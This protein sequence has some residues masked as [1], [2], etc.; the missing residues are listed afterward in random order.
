MIA[1]PNSGIIPVAARKRPTADDLAAILAGDDKPKTLY[2]NRPL[3]NASDVIEWARAAGFEKTLRPDD[4][5][6]TIAFSKTPVDWSEVGDSFDGVVVPRASKQKNGARSVEKLGD[7]GAVVLRFES[8]DLTQRWQAIRNVGG[9]WDYPSYKPHITFTM[10]DGDID[11]SAIE[12]YQGALEF[13]PEVFQEIGS[14]GSDWAAKAKSS[15]IGDASAEQWWES[16]ERDR[17][18]ALSARQ[19]E[20]EMEMLARL[21]SPA[22]GPT[23]AWGEAGGG[24]EDKEFNESDHP[25]DGGKFTSGG[26]TSAPEKSGGRAE[27]IKAHIDAIKKHA[28]ATKEFL[29]DKPAT[30]I[31][32][33]LVKHPKAKEGLSF[34]LQSLLSHAT[35]LDQSTWKLNEEF[36]DH[37][38]HHF[39]D[40]AALT[41]VQAK[42]TM[43]TA[44][45]KMI[46]QRDAMRKGRAMQAHDDEDGVTAAL[47]ALL[48]LLSD[49]KD[50]A[51]TTAAE[52]APGASPSA[53]TAEGPGASSTTKIDREHDGPWMSC[54]SRDGG[55]MYVNSNL[56]EKFDGTDVADILLHHEVPEWRKLE[57]LLREFKS[58]FD[59][60]PDEEER[61]AIY[62]KAHGEDGTPS[63]RAYCDEAGID[64]KAWSAWCRGEES[65]I[66]K[67]TPKNPPE[68]ADVKPIPHGHGDLEA[69]MGGDSALRLALD[70]DSVREF[71]RD[72]RMH[73][74]EANVC[75]ACVSPYR[76]G[77]I[78]DW[79]K[80]GLEQDRI[81]KLLRDPDELE[82]AAPTLNGV[83]LLRKHIPVS[84]DDHQPW[85]VVGAVGTTARWDAPFIK[86]G[87]SI[88]SGPDIEGVKSG[89]KRE[90]SPGYHYKAVMGPGTFDGEA[91]DGKMTDIVFNHVAIVTDG[92]QG[93]DVI[94]GDSADDVLWTIIERELL[95]FA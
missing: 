62:L 35:G 41:A 59:R 27:K 64:W 23:E 89:E 14:R 56:P 42:A 50:A 71:D 43:R 75:K 70:R 86:N 77:E 81:Y 2:I 58:K 30:E 94:I 17:D 5:H 33:T 28:G 91:Y 66:E 74:A 65:K 93:S 87:L 15:L 20:D 26:G 37:T 47:A 79:E 34:A 22:A 32:G 61:K 78:P 63:E 25:R 80:M 55:T 4:I 88:W 31:I 12:P 82:K 16:T 51:A 24:G 3:Q 19:H 39:A 8:P 60:E 6:V 18:R 21:L 67:L 46:E 9:S 38:I 1:A 48:D 36:I 84:A 13:G 73:I 92:R 90:L 45:Q 44:V 95:A 68:D 10:V 72:G 57:A 83:Q 49:D 69:T 85:D 40:I 7:H 11:L 54:M 76:G 53:V 29:R 52:D